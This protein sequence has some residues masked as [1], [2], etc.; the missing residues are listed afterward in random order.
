MVR[1]WWGEER[2]EEG[3][4]DRQKNRQCDCISLI[5]LGNQT[6]NKRLY[7]PLGIK[8]NVSHIFTKHLFLCTLINSQDGRGSLHWILSRALKGRAGGLWISKP[9][10]LLDIWQNSNQCK[11]LYTNATSPLCV[12]C[13][14]ANQLPIGQFFTPP[15]NK[16][17]SSAPM[18][19]D[20]LYIKSFM[21]FESQ[22]TLTGVREQHRNC[23]IWSDLWSRDSCLMVTKTSYFRGNTPQKGLIHHYQIVQAEGALIH[24]LNYSFPVLTLDIFVIFENV[25]CLIT[26]SALVIV[27]GSKF[28]LCMPYIECFWFTRFECTTFWFLWTSSIVD[29]GFYSHT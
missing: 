21:Q 2:G 9:R 22:Q 7:L 27:C 3:W 13:W 5:S 23:Y 24:L 17:T 11:V 10:I 20:A 28:F 18:V 4:F 14:L 16:R 12:H 1:S 15:Q 19:D 29:L 25:V 26:T 8:Q 6:K